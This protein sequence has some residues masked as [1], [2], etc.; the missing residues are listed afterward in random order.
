[1]SRNRSQQTDQALEVLISRLMIERRL[2]M[3]TCESCTGGLILHRLTNVPGSS[4]YVMGGFV[5]YSNEA[6]VKFAH[7]RKKTLTSTRLRFGTDICL[8]V[9]GI[10]GPGGGTESK[11]VGL[12]YVALC[13]SEIERV[14]RYIWSGNREANKADSAEAALYALY[15]YLGN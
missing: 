13:T 14:E 2:T 4:S 1:M 5:T 11:P 10:A 8:S 12:T 6:K 15:A 3:S 7:V 9:T